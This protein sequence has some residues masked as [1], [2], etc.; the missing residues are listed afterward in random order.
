MTC[1]CRWVDRSNCRLLFFFTHLWRHER[2]SLSLVLRPINTMM[3]VAS[4]TASRARSDDE[5]DALYH[6]GKPSARPVATRR[7]DGGCGRSLR[8]SSSKMA[9]HRLP[10]P[11][12]I[13][14]HKPHLHTSSYLWD[15]ALSQVKPLKGTGEPPG[16]EPRTC[17]WS[18][19]QLGKFAE[20]NAL[21]ESRRYRGLR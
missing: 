21:L 8:W 9:R 1:C 10:P 6:G 12:L 14:P 19:R 3:Y 20:G 17:P 7:A 18:V 5:L 2:C 15:G 11:A 16:I 4:A 13:S